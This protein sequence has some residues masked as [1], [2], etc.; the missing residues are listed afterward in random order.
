MLQHSQIQYNI[1]E[2]KLEVSGDHSPAV[3][4]GS[5]LSQHEHPCEV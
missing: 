1:L 5:V 3:Q 2:S 4:L